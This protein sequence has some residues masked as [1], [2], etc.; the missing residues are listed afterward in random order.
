MKRREFVGLL[1]GAAAFPLAARVAKA[2]PHSRFVVGFLGPQ[3][4]GVG[5]YLDDVA[6]GLSQLGYQQGRDYVFEERY[7]EGEMARLPALAEDLVRFKPNV[8]IVPTTVAALAAR[9]ATTEIPIV[10]VSLADPHG[11]RA[12]RSASWHQRHRHTHVGGR[13]WGKAGKYCS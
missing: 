8:I 1:G 3:V 7:A 11:S 5:N 2:Q 13:A 10:G 12:Q 9:K 6:S 4:G